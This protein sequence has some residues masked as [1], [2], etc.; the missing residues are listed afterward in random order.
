MCSSQRNTKIYLWFYKYHLSGHI[1]KS[2]RASCFS[3]TDIHLD[4]ISYFTSFVI[5]RSHFKVDGKFNFTVCWFLSIFA[6]AMTTISSLSWHVRTFVV[7]MAL[8]FG[9]K[10]HHV[11]WNLSYD[12]K[13]YQNII[14]GLCYRYWFSSPDIVFIAQ[15]CYDYLSQDKAACLWSR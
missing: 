10:Q 4:T 1:I 6:H 5:F 3:S 11:P 8:N 2:I 12:K 7:I 15:Y 13:N 9:W 14:S